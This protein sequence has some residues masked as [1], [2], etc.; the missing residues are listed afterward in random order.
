MFLVCPYLYGYVDAKSVKYVEHFTMTLEIFD[1]VY[2]FLLQIPWSL[3]KALIEGCLRHKRQLNKCHV[4][5]Y[6][7]KNRKIYIFGTRKNLFLVR[8]GE[9]FLWKA[10]P[11]N[12][13]KKRNRR[14]NFYKGALPK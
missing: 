14:I 12:S 10:Q 6:R 13:N 11:S 5:V 3:L 2:F 1:H 7:C 4:N 9:L 8:S